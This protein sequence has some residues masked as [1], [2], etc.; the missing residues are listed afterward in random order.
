MKEPL[1]KQSCSAFAEL[2]SSRA[3]VP[4]GGGAA[5]L[6]GALGAALGA[7]A[8]RLSARGQEEA[9]D[10]LV[11][12]ADGL[13]LR[14]LALVDADAEGFA[15]LAA[16]Y[17][18]P[19][20]APDRAAALCAATR[21]ACQAPL[22]MMRA[23]LD[24]LLLLE[25]LRPLCKPLLLSDVGCGAALCGAALEAAAMNVFVNTHSLP[26]E[27]RREWEAMAD[28]WLREGKERA[29]ALTADVL[30]ELRKE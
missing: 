7:M 25:Q 17:A 2:L 27:Q 11:E 21:E 20:D 4:G 26:A 3:A 29:A 28:A 30:A 22:G 6:C 8:G 5:A 23:C 10:P 19:K 15:P 18:L 9:L 1:T 16:A 14:L 13:R 24:A 12:R